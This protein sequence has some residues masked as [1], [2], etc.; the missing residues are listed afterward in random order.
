MKKIKQKKSYLLNF[1]ISLVVLGAIDD[2]CFPVIRI[3]F[4]NMFSHC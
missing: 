4:K 2:Y 1:L 3:T